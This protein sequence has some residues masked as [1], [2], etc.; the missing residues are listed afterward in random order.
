M[1]SEGGGGCR[2]LPELFTRLAGGLHDAGSG[3]VK[4]ETPWSC[5]SWGNAQCDINDTS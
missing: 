1:C 2:G 3:I 5:N 4:T